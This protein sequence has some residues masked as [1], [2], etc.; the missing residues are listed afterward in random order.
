MPLVRGPIKNNK[1]WDK[2]YL[3]D[4][5]SILGTKW[6]KTWIFDSSIIISDKDK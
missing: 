3:H 2:A 6:R 1:N 4:L 5:S